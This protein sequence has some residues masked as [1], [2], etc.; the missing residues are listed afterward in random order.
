MATK[1]LLARVATIRAPGGAAAPFPPGLKSLAVEVSASGSA[2]GNAAVRAFVRK[3]LPA[4]SYASPAGQPL[5]AS[6]RRA[7]DGGRPRVVA[8]FADGKTKEVAGEG[9]TDEAIFAALT[10]GASVSLAKPKGRR[11]G[12]P[13]KKAAAAG[14]DGAAAGGGAPAS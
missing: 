13:R 2:P 5:A 10:G 12:A 6:V 1:A 9:A 3:Y 8:S 11:A 4:L 7:A 14:G